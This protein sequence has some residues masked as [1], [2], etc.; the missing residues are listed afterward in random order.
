MST[1]A[2]DG[3]TFKLRRRK[4]VCFLKLIKLLWPDYRLSREQQMMVRSAQEDDE[5]IVPA[6][7]AM[8]KDFITSLI[9]LIFFITREPCRIVVTSVNGPHLGVI[10]GELKRHID[11]CK[12][13]LDW[14]KGGMLLINSEQIRKIR[15]DGTPCPI[16][17]IKN[18]VCSDDTKESLQGHHATPPT[19]AQ[20][21]LNE[22][23]TMAVTDESSSIGDDKIT[24]L[25]T[26]CKR[27]IMIGNCWPC[28]SYFRYAVEGSPDGL[29]KGGDILRPN[30]KGFKR[31]IIRIRAADSPNV[32]FALHQLS[33]GMSDQDDRFAPLIVAGLRL[34]WDWKFLSDN[35]DPV[36][37]A[38]QIDAI[39][40]KGSELLLFPPKWI[41]HSETLADRLGLSHVKLRKAKAIGVDCAEG[42]DK[43]VL[44]AGDEYGVIDILAL[45]TPDTSV[46]PGLIRGFAKKHGVPPQNVILD[47]GGG[48]KEHADT[49]RNQGFPV[50]TVAFNE[51]PSNKPPK[52]Q[53]KTTKERVEQFED[54]NVYKN[55]RA[56]MYV[57][58]SLWMNPTGRKGGYGIP[59]T[60]EWAELKRQLS[61]IPKLYDQDGML[62][63]L[64]KSKK[65]KNSKEKT[66]TQIIGCSPDEAD[67]FVMMTYGV[68]NRQVVGNATAPVKTVFDGYQYR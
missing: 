42:G 14:K 29:D 60:P 43:T 33:K 40:Y 6:A 39:W 46:I 67:A 10:W 17:Y 64:P 49:L 28:D 36:K 68:R 45:K 44:I 53:S 20:A 57:E 31:R 2:T 37:K 50:R 47:R 8:G 16:S 1:T 52:G 15:K 58:A 19:H 5:T 7:N 59:A 34:Y 48:G 63:M 12:V 4:P 54:K 61:Y 27:L 35:L 18:L 65:D 51:S 41:A 25:K 13:P 56:E 66:L 38:A 32:R 30:G 62:W 24:M 3:T 22:A 23:L 9:I 11:A 21:L 26:W 55:R